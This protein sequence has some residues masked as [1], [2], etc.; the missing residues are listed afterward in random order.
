MLKIYILIFWV[1]SLAM[2]VAAEGAP[3]DNF[4]IAKDYLVQHAKRRDRLYL[5]RAY[6]IA[7]D[8]P[9]KAITVSGEQ[10]R[11]A[12][13]RLLLEILKG[14]H[15]EIDPKFKPET[16]PSSYPR[17]PPEASDLDMGVHPSAISDPIIRQKYI[18]AREENRKAIEA[19][20]TELDLR[21]WQREILELLSSLLERR[22]S[23]KERTEG[24]KVIK[25]AK[26]D[27]AI[28]AELL[29]GKR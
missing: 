15:T 9:E 23:G 27:S 28:E 11:T 13:L 24:E 12:K 19:Y 29:N 6:R 5:Q 17:L 3:Q 10:M 14:V 16:P 4:A 20:L 21:E 8:L 1:L 2:S 25:S 7:R 22:F 26:L 18:D